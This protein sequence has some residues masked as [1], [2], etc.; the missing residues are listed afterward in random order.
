MKKFL[1]IVLALCMV[2]SL[3]ACGGDETEN[4]SAPE[5]SKEEVASKE[6]SK[7]EA[8][9]SEDVAES[10][11]ASEAESSEASETSEASEAESSEAESSEAES[12]EAESSEE[13][14]EESKEEAKPSEG[15]VN[16]ALNATYTVLKEGVAEDPT[17][18]YLGLSP[19]A[20]TQ[21]TDWDDT[22]CT[23][24]NDG[25]VAEGS[26]L[27]ANGALAGTT[28]QLVG[29]G[30]M[31]S[32]VFKLDGNY[33]DIKSIVFRNVRNGV[34]NS[35][36]RGF[37]TTVFPMIWVSDDGNTWGA[38]LTG[39]CDEGVQVEGAPE[40][41]DQFDPNIL[42]VENFDYTYTL[43]TA[44]SGCYIKIDIGGGGAPAYVV[45]LD[46]IE[47]WNK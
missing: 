22:A 34:A 14:K 7:E 1:L 24:M 35:N 39:S 26:E 32:Y 8:A 30:A 47:I 27:D 31:Y 21:T 9:S 19:T 25:I 42:N 33:S 12:S 41:K 10:S 45:Q 6:E 29:T 20:T 11:E 17:A 16:Y 36:N 46:E 37:D 43:D 23:K 2:L 28:V 40:I 4:S 38:P 5:A 3:A 13:S 18:I 44:A 15:E